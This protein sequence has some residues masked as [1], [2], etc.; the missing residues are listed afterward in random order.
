M[1]AMTVRLNDDE[2]KKNMKFLIDNDI[3]TFQQCLIILCLMRRNKK[4][5]S[6]DSKIKR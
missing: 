3:K 2:Y 4:N 1:K 5:E 6:N